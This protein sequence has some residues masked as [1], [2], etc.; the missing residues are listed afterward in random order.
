MGL[1]VLVLNVISTESS[2][3][4]RPPCHSVLKVYFMYLWNAF[5]S[6]R[7]NT[8]RVTLRH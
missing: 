3:L 6:L 4:G 8:G 5:L 7:K 1:D 2:P